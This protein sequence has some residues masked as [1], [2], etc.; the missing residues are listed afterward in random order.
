MSSLS[1]FTLV[2]S[3]CHLDLPEFAA[4]REMVLARARAAGVAL[5]VNPGI[6]LDH[7]R[8]ALRL[9]ATIDEVYAAV[10]IHPNSAGNWD[11]ETLPHLR[12]MVQAPKVVAIGEI[13]LD[14]YWNAAPPAVQEAVFRQQLALAADVG[15][16]VIIHSREANDAVA[17]V[18]REWVASRAFQE[19][20]LARRP[21]AGVLHAFSGGQALAEEA[22]AWNFVLGLGGPVTFRNARALHELVPKLRL[23]RLLLET[24]APYL[25]P[26]PHRGARNEPAYVSLVC[27]QLA[28]IYGVSLAV[29]AAQTTA[30]ARRFYGL[31]DCTGVDSASRRVA[32]HA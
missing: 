15:L 11:A 19:S 8:E 7:C 29:V 4:D 31:E 32:I 23:D 24:D 26:H 30:T 13:G 3:H 25:T 20:A 28:Q 17:A 21:F 14:F 10:G 22:Y 5:I 2:D 18:L 27:A 16:P 1:T 9:A 12:Q 6:D